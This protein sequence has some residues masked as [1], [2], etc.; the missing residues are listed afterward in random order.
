M[1]LRIFTVLK[2]LTE[3]IYSRVDGLRV[4]MSQDVS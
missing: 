2:L 4:S 3:I 1:S